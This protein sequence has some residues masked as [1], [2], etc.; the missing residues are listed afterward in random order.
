MMKLEDWMPKTHKYCSFCKKYRRMDGAKW[1]MEEHLTAR[2]LKKGSDRVIYE[3][4]LADVMRDERC[5]R[6]CELFWLSKW[7]SSP[8]SPERYGW[9]KEQKH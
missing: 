3:K 7:E 5:S 8:S 2:P 9:T 1:K 4:M 6:G